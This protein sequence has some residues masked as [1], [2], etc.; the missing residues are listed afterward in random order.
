MLIAFII[1]TSIYLTYLGANNGWTKKL[2]QCDGL[3]FSGGFLVCI[4]LL[5]MVSNLG[6]FNIFSYQTG[7]KRLPTGQ[8]ENLTD[9]TERKEVNRKKHRLDFLSYII[10]AIPFLIASLM[11]MIAM[12]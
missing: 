12:S 3:F 7:R 1:G 10:V 4:G 9:Y 6:G 8:K 2:M 11:I 5:A